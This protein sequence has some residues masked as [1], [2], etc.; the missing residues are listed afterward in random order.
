ML[1][2]AYHQH[3]SDRIGMDD[4]VQR[5]AAQQPRRRIAQAIRRPRM[6]H[7]V[8]RQRKQENDKADE[9][10]REVEVLQE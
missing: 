8:Y 7:F 1:D 10:A 3:R 4:R 9:D 5:D 6:R 2:Y